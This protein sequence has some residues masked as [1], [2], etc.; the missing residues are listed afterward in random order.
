VQ[1]ARTDSAAPRPWAHW[2]CNNSVQPARRKHCLRRGPTRTR[3]P[4]AL[5]CPPSPGKERLT[6]LPDNRVAWISSALASM[7]PMRWRWT[8]CRS[9]PDFAA[10]VPPP[11]CIWFATAACSHPPVR[12]G[13][14]SFPRCPSRQL[15]RHVPPR[16]RTP[17]RLPSQPARSPLPVLGR[18]RLMRLNLGLPSTPAQLRGTH[19]LRALVRTPKHGA[20]SP[21][22]S[23]ERAPRPA[24]PPRPLLPQHH[25]P[26]ATAQTEL[27]E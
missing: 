18:G 4:A 26:Q 8:C 17:R 12:G 14:W 7:A 16:R 21:P 6:L 24:E 20:S 15:L 10:S 9:W 5:T 2:S 13:H 22:G 1:L 19:E 27:F 23:V 3:A 25:P 11:N